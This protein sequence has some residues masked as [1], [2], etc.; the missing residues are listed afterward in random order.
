MKKIKDF[1]PAEVVEILKTD[2]EKLGYKVEVNSERFQ[3]ARVPIYCQKGNEEKIIEY[4]IDKDI[5]KD[6]FFPTEEI[7]GI[8]IN[9]SS[10]VKFYQYYFPNA[11]IYFAIPYYVNEDD[12]FNEFKK[13]C[14]KNGIGILKIKSNSQIEEILEA[15]PLF[16]E[17]C[18]ELKITDNKKKAKLEYHL[19]NC[20]HLFIYYPNPVFNRRAITGKSKEKMSFILIDKLVELKK[21][22]YK[23]KLIKLAN[24]YRKESLPD[25]EIASNY[26]TDLWGNY[27]G[28]KYPSIQK[29]AENILQRNKNYREH[30]VHQF[31]VFLIG[32]Y[33]LDSVYD[34]VAAK[35]EENNNCK[36][37]DVWLAASTFHDFSYGL[38]KFDTWLMEFFEDILRIKNNQTKKDLNLLNLDAAMI[39]ETLYDQ[40]KKIVNKIDSYSKKENSIDTSTRF[41]YE[42][43]VRDRNHGVLSAI[44]LLKLFEES[45]ESDNKIKEQGIIEA[46]TAIAC[47]DEDIWE[48]LSGCQGYSRSHKD[49]PANAK[50]CSKQC[51]RKDILWPTKRIKILEERISFNNPDLNGSD[52]TCE[53]WEREIMSRRILSEIKF[54]DN[55]I[56]FLL[57]FCDTIQDEGRVS[58]TDSLIPNDRSVLD[59]VS[60][61]NNGNI[62]IKISLK[63]AEK[64]AKDKESEIE[65]VA[66]MLKDPRFSI[67]INQGQSMKMNG[68]GGL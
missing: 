18:R 26:I 32:A 6:K 67:S 66:W 15:K 45:E 33:I 60:I 27:L 25:F 56:L 53:V 61:I 22:H 47:H 7:G 42:K 19:R 21:I 63:S 36:I 54:K 44:T 43:A 37:E 34:E 14:I 20:L 4:T 40:I 9:E 48:A 55:P 35:F 23:D 65:R 38:Q 41:F 2:N 3:P 62:Q 59:N 28:L 68:S 31:Q 46:A 64:Y 16:E 24:S 51:R 13:T 8:E 1:T 58:S 39:R 11:K 49:L 30:F 12:G 52:A 5:T 29:R 50:D 10:P 17:I 57:I